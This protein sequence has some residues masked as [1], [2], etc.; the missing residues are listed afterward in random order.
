MYAW[1]A[2]P[3][4]PPQGYIS[5]PHPT[6]LQV[7]RREHG[8]E[9]VVH[10]VVLGRHGRERPRPLGRVGGVQDEPPPAVLGVVGA[11]V[12][13]AGVLAGEDDGVHPGVQLPDLLG[14]GHVRAE[15]REALALPREPSFQMHLP[16]A[17]V[18]ASDLGKGEGKGRVGV[19]LHESGIEFVQT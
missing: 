12:Q 1:I 19:R 3:F 18:R 9:D 6:Y 13:V 15:V 4:L 2:L 17:L 14:H 10:R 16:L 11:V 7:Q 8:Q 5:P